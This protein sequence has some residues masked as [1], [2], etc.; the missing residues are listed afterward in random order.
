MDQDECKDIFACVKNT[1]PWDC[2]MMIDETNIA[3]LLTCIP[4]S[5]RHFQ[6]CHRH[7]KTTR[8]HFDP[9]NHKGVEAQ[10]ALVVE[11]KRECHFRSCFHLS[12]ERTMTNKKDLPQNWLCSVKLC[13]THSRLSQASKKEFESGKSSQSGT[14]KQ[15][16]KQSKKSSLGYQTT[17]LGMKPHCRTIGDAVFA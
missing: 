4:E 9:N 2:K 16:V 14:R 10:N 6:K 5:E 7:P 3:P 17:V 13:C 12:I 15:M 8:H 11:L 1:E